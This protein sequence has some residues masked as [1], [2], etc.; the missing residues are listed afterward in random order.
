MSGR[1]SLLLCSLAFPVSLAA[2]DYADGQAAYAS[3]DWFAAQKLWEDEAAAGSAE[4]MLGL[5]N[6]YDFGLLGSREPERAFELYLQAAE[7]NLPEAAFNVAVMYDSGIGVAQ[8][9]QSAAAWYSYAALAGHGRS[10]YNLGQLFQDGRDIPENHRLAAFW[11]GRA[12]ATIPSAAEALAA[13]PL[14][15]GSEQG[16]LDAPAPLGA[17]TFSGPDGSAEVRMAWESAGGLG[18]VTYQVELLRMDAD[19]FSPLGTARTLG[20]AAAVSLPQRDTDF[21]WR[22]SELQGDSYAASAW[23]SAD[24]ATLDPAP[25][26]TVRFEYDLADRR[27]EGLAYRMGGAMERFGAI[28]LYEGIDGVV[29]TSSVTYGYVQDALLATDVATFLPGLAGE[30]AEIVTEQTIIPGEIRVALA[31]TGAGN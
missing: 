6:L 23:Q 21:A 7:A 3:R 10:A 9:M 19:R 28:V 11:Y 30:G 13:L 1:L 12:S 16:E 4:A 22:V 8:Q 20:S 25:V 14:L 18:D 2:Q 17:H 15:A 27:A 24:G 5:G 29:E 31:F 26:G